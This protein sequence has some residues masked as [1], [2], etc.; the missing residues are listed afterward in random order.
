MILERV[1]CISKYI[2]TRLAYALAG[3]TFFI[4]EIKKTYNLPESSPYQRVLQERHE[5]AI[6][7]DL[8]YTDAILRDGWK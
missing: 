1:L 2:P 6:S 7:E 4:E 8:Y 5:K 3:N